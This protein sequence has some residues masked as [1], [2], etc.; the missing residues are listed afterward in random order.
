MPHFT[1]LTFSN[2]TIICR[3]KTSKKPK[4]ELG[5][6]TVMLINLSNAQKNQANKIVVIG[7]TLVILQAFNNPDSTFD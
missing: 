1:P 6:A 2:H 3:Y 4:S 7:D 5:E